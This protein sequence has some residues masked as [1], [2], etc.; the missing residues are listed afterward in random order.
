MAE[1]PE[2]QED[3]GSFEAPFQSSTLAEL[4]SSWLLFVLR[5]VHA[6]ACLVASLII[7]GFGLDAFLK[8]FLAFRWLLLEHHR[9]MVVQDWVSVL[10]LVTT[11]VL[12]ILVMAGIQQR[13]VWLLLDALKLDMFQDYRRTVCFEGAGP[14]TFTHHQRKVEVHSAEAM[15]ALRS[16]LSVDGTVLIHH[17]VVHPHWSSRSSSP[18][19][20]IIPKGSR[21]LRC[22]SSRVQSADDLLEL[23]TPARLV[24]MVDG[25]AAALFGAGWC[26]RC[27]AFVDIGWQLVI[28]VTFDIVPF[29][30]AGNEVGW[31][32]LFG[33][34]W[35][36]CLATGLIEVACGH[37]LFFFAWS[38]LVDYYLKARALVS[39]CRTF[40]GRDR[41][42]ASLEDALHD[43]TGLDRA[44]LDA[45]VEKSFG[46]PAQELRPSILIR[47]AHRGRS[48]RYAP[49]SPGGR[50]S[51][52][53]G[54]HTSSTEY[55]SR[56]DSLNVWVCI[57]TLVLDRKT[58]CV[59]MGGGAWCGLLGGF[60]LSETVHGPML[61]LLLSILLLVIVAFSVCRHRY[62]IRENRNLTKMPLWPLW[63]RMNCGVDYGS[64]VMLAAVQLLCG[65]VVAFVV[66]S[67]EMI[68]VA[69]AFMAWNL[70]VLLASLSVHK[71]W[72]ALLVHNVMFGALAVATAAHADGRQQ[73]AAVAL[74]IFFSQLGFW[75]LG[76]D[77]WHIL[78]KNFFVIVLVGLAALTF[79]A[80]SSPSGRVFGQPS[81]D[82]CADPEDVHCKEFTVPLR[83]LP[84]VSYDFCSMSW[85]MGN[86]LRGVQGTVSKRCN[87]TSLTLVDFG[88]L[89]AVAGYL[90]AT[91]NCTL[92]EMRDAV[93]PFLEE[94]LPGWE[95]KY[96]QVYNVQE[97][98]HSTFVHLVRGGTSVIAVRGTS[99]A[100][101]V[102]K[103]V[104]LWMPVSFLQ[105]T[106]KFGPSL[107]STG[108]MLESFT[109]RDQEYRRRFSFKDIVDY[110]ATVKAN[111]KQG[112]RLYLTGHSLGGG[113]ANAVGAILDVPAVTFS[114][115]GLEATS[116]ILR[117]SPPVKGLI[118]R[119][120]T[121]VP[122]RDI[123]PQVDRQVGTV[124]PIDCTD[125][126]PFQCHRLTLTLCELLAAC[127]DGGGRAIPRGYVRSCHV[128]PDLAHTSATCPRHKPPP[129][130]PPQKNIFRR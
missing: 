95:V 71:R 100:A 31:H 80:V 8:M 125:K 120:V 96:S 57:R 72:K 103:D 62:G 104:T 90:S 56:D 16:V 83:G 86:D 121:V 97:K 67:F 11:G 1:E 47:E 78:F 117:P 73:G 94:Y 106:E 34:R 76:K 74:L 107:Y 75:R 115:P 126:N 7:A 89:A 82:W 9:V 3:V 55:W 52:A 42:S 51:S 111:L 66:P 99:S 60:L 113:L 4:Q 123:V 88:H 64:G 2:E 24:F 20:T 61:M 40:G 118:E 81:F 28:Y 41:S 37:I 92:G 84:D 108:L 105:L 44:R 15:E 13:G 85:E 14:G 124:L 12:M 129:G 21:L 30:L 102:L 22:E 53:S 19:G 46:I 110:V 58:A 79:L 91:P 68:L 32:G 93:S 63:F 127:G 114:S 33:W 54:T 38:T 25:R 130:P 6:W 112:E 17:Y 43:A 119:T 10:S 59:L 27:R 116:S 29:F 23:Y 87:D 101:E 45:E 69:A 109:K 98:K 49:S 35:L 39:M 36:E 50:P 48:I 65:G 128:C 5:G 26:A 18:S 70:G 122:A 77:Q